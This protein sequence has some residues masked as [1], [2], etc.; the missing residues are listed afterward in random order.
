VWGLVPD[1]NKQADAL[2]DFVNKE[3]ANKPAAFAGGNLQGRPRKI[4]FIGPDNPDSQACTTQAINRLRAEGVSVAD[5]RSYPLDIASLQ[6]TAQRFVSELQGEGVTTVIL[7][8]DPIT[9]FFMTSDAAQAGWT[10]EWVVGGALLDQDFV[11]QLM[12]QDEW[13]HAFG[14]SL[15]GQL[16]PERA[17]AGFTAYR[18]ESPTTDPAKFVVDQA[19]YELYQLAA[20][21]QMA[22]PE[23]NPATFAAGLQRYHGGP[24]PAGTWAFPPGDYTAPQDARIIW[25]KP[26]GVSQYNGALGTFDDNGGR[27]Y[28]LGHFPAGNPP[29]FLKGSQ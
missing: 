16:L 28:P 5:S 18:S 3:L 24:G 10:P 12:N 8:T 15:F 2:A 27:R 14:I 20:G 23:L 9:P 7:E 6:P 19:Y 13:S 1:C 25:W 11:G 21:I 29:V 22:G 17:T 4:A 26:S